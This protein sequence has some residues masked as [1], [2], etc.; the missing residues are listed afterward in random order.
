MRTTLLLSMLLLAAPAF[1]AQPGTITVGGLTREYLLRLPPG[2][3][4]LTPLPLVVA[5]HGG[6]GSGPQLEIQSQL[7]ATAAA[8]N[9]IVVYPSGVPSPLNIRTWNAGWC[10]GY[11]SNNT[12]DDVGFINALLDTL[13]ATYAIDTLRIHATGMSNGGF[14]SYRLACELAHRI[15]SIAPVSASMSMNS[16]SPDRPVPVVAIHSYQDMSVP[17]LGGVGSGVSGHYNNAQ[18]SVLNA[19]AAYAAC[20]VLNDTLLHDAEQTVVAW[21]EC[22]CGAEMRLHITADGG[23]SWH[24]GSGTPIGDPPSTTVSAND[25]MWAFFQE[26][27]LTCSPGTH[28]RG[29]RSSASI[30]VYPNPAGE[31]FRIAGM[32][33][34]RIV[35]RD[36][37]GRIVLEHTGPPTDSTE[38]SV[39]EGWSGVHLLELHATHGAVHHRRIVFGQ[40]SR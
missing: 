10:C 2:Y 31:R 38:L 9:F 32:A 27:P 24:G 16:C 25:L 40:G 22:A 33:C 13:T 20:A 1:I 30:D 18:D 37:L 39:P 17:Y 35:V 7:T 4:G 15:A 28:V 34:A 23:H 3:D 36:A 5:M 11:A 21:R 26:H 6:F 14:M 29:N 12:I 8:G 19:W